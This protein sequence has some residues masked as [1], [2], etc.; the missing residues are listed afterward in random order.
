[1]V[2]S[3]PDAATA[4]S[5]EAPELDIAR[6][7]V[8][9]ALPLGAVLIGVSALIWRGSGAAT[10]AFAM[11]IIVVNLL[12]AAGLMAWS[13]KISPTVL[14]AAVFGGFIVRMA[15]IALAIFLVKDASWVQLPL[16]AFS[17]LIGQ[18]GLLFWETR[19]VSGSLAFPGLKPG[20]AVPKEARP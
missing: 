8:R 10:A 11:G 17:L 13:A 2:R 15:V 7:I 18:L 9:H 14:M 5:T 20:V 4:A 6:D 3:V 19:Y 16:L 12:A 1:M